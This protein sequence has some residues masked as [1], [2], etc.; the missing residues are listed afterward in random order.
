MKKLLFFIILSAIA[1]KLKAQEKS[2]A[3]PF[4]K[5]ALK[6]DLSIKPVYPRSF[7]NPEALFKPKQLIASNNPVT[8]SKVD[9]MPIVKPVGK[10]NMPIIKPGGNYKMPI[11]GLQPV[12]KDSTQ[13][14]P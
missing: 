10:W 6:D 11:I 2:T 9:Q 7:I 12:K 13:N 1:L 14:Q 3:K 8:Y 4:E 5:E